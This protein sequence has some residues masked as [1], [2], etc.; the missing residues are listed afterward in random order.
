MP[1]TI[2]LL[3]LNDDDREGQAILTFPTPEAR[4]AYIR[5]KAE[6]ITE[7]EEWQD[8]IDEAG[9]DVDEAA[10]AVLDSADADYFMDEAE[11]PDA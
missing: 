8:A 3:Y 6:A 4:D 7:A 10:R 5:D 9:G 1:R 11:I 2:Y